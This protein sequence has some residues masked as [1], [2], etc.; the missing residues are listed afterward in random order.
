MSVSHGEEHGGHLWKEQ[1]SG[2]QDEE[3]KVGQDGGRR[4]SSQ[5]VNF[6]QAPTIP[7][8]AR[9]AHAIDGMHLEKNV[10]ENT[11]CLLLEIKG[12]RKDSLKSWMDLINQV[13]GSQSA[14]SC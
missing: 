2:E 3:E 14:H 12:K 8:R 13:I 10:F 1:K 9:S 5:E 7:E 11:I 6:L 4:L